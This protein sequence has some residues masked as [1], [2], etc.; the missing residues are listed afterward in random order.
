[1]ER[2]NQEGSA[3]EEHVQAPDARGNNR[4]PSAFRRFWAAA[5]VGFVCTLIVWFGLRLLRQP[6]LEPLTRTGWQQAWQRWNE[7]GPRNYE[8]VVETSGRQAATYKVIVQGGEPSSATC[9]GQPL[10]QPRAWYTW[11]VPGMF[12]TL[13]RDL[14][15]IERAQQGTPKGV[16]LSVYVA[17]D[18]QYG[19][20]ARYLRSEHVASGSNPDV[21]WKVVSFQ[22]LGTDNP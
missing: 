7:R 18:P 22:P 13:E 10:P 14:E 6:G 9:N 12:E 20:P 1:M 21:T 17:F 15:Q 8:I 4:Y 19:Y 16:P 3:E 11:S 2:L 5:V